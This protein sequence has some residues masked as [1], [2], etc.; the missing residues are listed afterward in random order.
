M[1]D[2]L[3]QA[4]QVLHARGIDGGE[5]ARVPDIG[6][7]CA[8]SALPFLDQIAAVVT[9]PRARRILRVDALGRHELSA[10]AAERDVD[11]VAVRELDE[12]AGD[13]AHTPRPRAAGPRRT[14]SCDWPCART[15]QPA[16]RA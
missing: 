11:A 1:C 9:H 2:G 7:A 13:V 5:L 15:P 8:V 3:E 10:S 6:A 14:P 12:L 4:E 16:S